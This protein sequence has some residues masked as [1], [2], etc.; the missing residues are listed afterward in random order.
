ML[1]MLI[2]FIFVSLFPSI[3]SS[4]K[5]A[6]PT[7]PDA[8]LAGRVLATDG[9]AIARATTAAAAAAATVAA[10]TSGSG[11]VLQDPP[12]CLAAQLLRDCSAWDIPNF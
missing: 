7:A 11:F 1:F 2:V 3:L 5:M 9:T 6:S 4:S 12:I 8:S 10:T